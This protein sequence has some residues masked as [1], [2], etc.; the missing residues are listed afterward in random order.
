MLRRGLLIAVAAC[1]LP[2]LLFPVYAIET[3][4]GRDTCFLGHPEGARPGV[5]GWSWWPLGT[6]CSLILPDGERLEQTVPPWRGTADWSRL[7]IAQND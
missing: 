2:V 3:E 7:R 6:R 5:E 1:G 4:S